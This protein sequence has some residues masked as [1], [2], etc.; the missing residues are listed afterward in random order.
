MLKGNY[1][2]SKPDFDVT[3]SG[4]QNVS[5]TFRNIDSYNQPVAGFSITFGMAYQFRK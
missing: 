5:P 3:Y 2:Y 4:V 1:F